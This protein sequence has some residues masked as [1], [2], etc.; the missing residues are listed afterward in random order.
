MRFNQIQSNCSININSSLLRSDLIL[1][2]KP[3]SSDCYVLAISELTVWTRFEWIAGFLLLHSI[4]LVR[5]AL[6]KIYLR[7][8]VFFFVFWE[9]EGQKRTTWRGR[10]Q[11]RQR[12]S[13][14]KSSAKKEMFT[15]ILF[16]NKSHTLIHG[17]KK[18]LN[19]P[20]FTFLHQPIQSGSSSP[21][22]YSS[23]RISGSSLRGE[24]PV[25][26]L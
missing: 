4:N 8:R 11:K 25:K 14:K 3:L 1:T 5:I 18:S 17:L 21:W 15:V 20:S 6:I 7:K 2:P 26:R 19:F 13:W 9:W 12:S 10:R 23:H 22:I 16:S 24:E